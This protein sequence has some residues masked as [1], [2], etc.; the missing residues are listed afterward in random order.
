MKN[1]NYIKNLLLF[2]LIAAIIPFSSCEDNDDTGGSSATPVIKAVYLEDPN[3]SVPDRLVEF[4]RLGQTIRIEG[5][6]LLGVNK[7]FLNGFEQLFNPALMT[8]NTML[9]QISSRVPTI[10]ATEDVRNTIRLEKSAGNFVVYNFEIRSAAPGISNVSHT[11]AQAGEVITLTGNGLQ[12]VS[13]VLFPGDIEGTNI[14][15][16]DENGEWCQVTVPAGITTSGSIKVTGANGGAFSPAYFNYKEGLLH[17]FD[18]VQNYSWG[19]GVD[20]TALTASIPTSGNLPKSQGGYQCFNASGSLGAGADQ[21]FWMNSKVASGLLAAIPASTPTDQ[22]GVQMDIYVEGAWNSGVIRFVM[23]DGWGT[24]MYD[25]LYQP[26]YPDGKTYDAAAFVNPGCW[27]TVTL[28]FSL[29]DDFASRSLADVL[30]Q[31]TIAETE[32]YNQIGPWFENS[33]IKDVFDPVPSTAK[34]YFDNIRVVPII[35]PAYSD[36]PDE[37]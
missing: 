6:S 3:S 1:K 23:A 26:V 28:P 7:L 24:G 12:E 18:D 32:K 13:R 34:V 2:G 31:M 35:T 17:N 11:M 14:V 4:A 36:Y 27:F 20:N 10:D 22:C 21:R 37:E 33:G 15:S 16:D 30:A 25:M 19:S 5:E 29:S 9:F 8:D